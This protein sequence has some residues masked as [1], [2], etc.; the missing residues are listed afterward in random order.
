[1]KTDSDLIKHWPLLLWESTNYMIYGVYLLKLRKGKKYQSLA[2]SSSYNVFH[3]SIRLSSRNRVFQQAN[4]LRR[5][6]YLPCSKLYQRD[7]SPDHR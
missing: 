7:E 2:R 5:I 6:Q 3:K 4:E 1:V